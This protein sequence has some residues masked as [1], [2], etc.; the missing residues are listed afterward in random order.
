MLF[1]ERYIQTT[2]FKSS[3]PNYPKKKKSRSYCRVELT[4]WEKK[5][6][7]ETQTNK[8]PHRKKTNSKTQTYFSFFSFFYQE[9]S[10]L[11]YTSSKEKQDIERNVCSIFIYSF[12]FITVTLLF[13]FFYFLLSPTLFFLTL[14]YQK[15][16]LSLSLPLSLSRKE[17]SWERK[18]HS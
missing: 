5:I 17:E 12:S 8:H 1:V 7:T 6:L 9:D 10:N 16:S 2:K 18:K 4:S 3:L 13:S 15:L 11:L 14:K